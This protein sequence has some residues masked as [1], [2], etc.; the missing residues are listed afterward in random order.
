MGFRLNKAQRRQ[1]NR[2]ANPV[3]VLRQSRP[4][5]RKRG[6]KKELPTEH[7]ERLWRELAGPALKRELELIPGRKFRSDYTHVPSKVTVEIH[8]GVWM[9]GRH[10]RGQGFRNDRIKRD[11]LED[12]GY[13]VYELTP[14]DVTA[15]MLGKIIRKIEERSK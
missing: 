12:L 11:L 7:F 5:R 10:V 2:G 14:D 15:E 1:L 9:G 6:E 13:K 8:G 3:K 4:S